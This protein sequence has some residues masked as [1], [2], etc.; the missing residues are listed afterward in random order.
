MVRE[1]PLLQYGAE[2]R[3]AANEC[4]FGILAEMRELRQRL[5]PISR[6]LNPIAR[7]LNIIAKAIWI[8][9][10]GPSL[11]GSETL[12]Q[13]RIQVLLYESNLRKLQTRNGILPSPSRWT[14]FNVS[15]G[16]HA[17]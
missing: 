4:G 6:N 13:V 14:C 17:D 2:R 15:Y 10:K 12:L 9:V 11:H 3:L 8:S 16:A 7:N 1:A 5:N